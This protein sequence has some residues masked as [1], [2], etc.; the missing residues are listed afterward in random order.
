L[1]RVS[2]FDPR[3]PHDL[4]N[5]GQARQGESKTMNDQIQNLL[6]QVG[7]KSSAGKYLDQLTTEAREVLDEFETWLR[8]DDPKGVKS[9]STARAY[10]GYCAK[11]IVEL[12][13]DPEFELDSDVKS[14]INA[15]HRFQQAV[16]PAATTAPPSSLDDMD[17]DEV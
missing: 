15:L 9:E 5:T 17:S 16:H 4:A 6:N 11:A 3:S 13:K 7:E 14:A 8:E 1:V 2:G 12:T 10:K